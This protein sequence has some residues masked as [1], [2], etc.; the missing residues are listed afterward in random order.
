GRVVAAYDA[1]GLPRSGPT[2][3]PVR[4]GE[5]AAAVRQDRLSTV[6]APF[7]SVGRSG[8]YRIRQD[9]DGNARSNDRFTPELCRLCRME[10]QIAEGRCL[11]VAPPDDRVGLFADLGRP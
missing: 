1:C 6:A 8:K 9:R 4:S 3:P 2:L 7:P 5:S 10:S 11:A